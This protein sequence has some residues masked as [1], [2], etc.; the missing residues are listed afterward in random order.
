M[1]TQKIY[2]KEQIGNAVFDRHNVVIPFHE[3]GSDIG[4]IKLDSERDAEK[5]EDIEKHIKNRVG[6]I[7]AS[8]EAEYEGKKKV[9]LWRQSMP[10]SDLLQVF[11]PR[12]QPQPPVA[13]DAVAAA[14]AD[15]VPPA[16]SGKRSAPIP[17]GD[18]IAELLTKPTKGVPADTEAPPAV[19]PKTRIGR[20][21]QGKTPEPITAP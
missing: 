20:A 3:V 10:Q 21:S 1:G 17:F 9:P 14:K 18:A 8:N 16:P 19:S 13:G 7:W 4:G 15:A 5:I 2:L 12:R 6:G 11:Q